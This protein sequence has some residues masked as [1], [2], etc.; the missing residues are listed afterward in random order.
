MNENVNIRGIAVGILILAFGVYMLIDT[1]ANLV[2]A[3]TYIRVSF[4]VLIFM[5][6]IFRIIRAVMGFKRNQRENR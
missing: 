4:I 5:Y 6:G 2:N 1:P 3:P